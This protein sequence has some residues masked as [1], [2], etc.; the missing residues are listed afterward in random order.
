MQL[1]KVISVL[2]SSGGVYPSGLM[3]DRGP[4]SAQPTS[5]LIFWAQALLELR[6]EPT[7]SQNTQQHF[8]LKQRASYSRGFRTVD[9]TSHA[10]RTK[11]CEET[12]AIRIIRSTSMWEN[13]LFRQLKLSAG[14][15]F[16]P[17]PLTSVNTTCGYSSLRH[18]DECYNSSLSPS[19]AASVYLSA[20]KDEETETPVMNDLEEFNKCYLAETNQASST[21]THRLQSGPL[22]S[23]CFLNG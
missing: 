9:Q 21:H 18:E 3:S 7:W 12:E 14:V 13:C 1:G 20:V 22:V 10:N 19:P 11:V 6:E 2:A 8:W 16:D 15:T 5:L 23:R 17:I 4:D